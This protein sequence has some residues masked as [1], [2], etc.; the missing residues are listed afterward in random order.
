MN[1]GLAL[2]HVHLVMNLKLIHIVIYL[3]IHIL[4]M[5]TVVRTVVQDD[6]AYSDIIRPSDSDQANWRGV[7]Q[8]QKGL[9]RYFMINEFM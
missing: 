3:P 6:V 7:R 2:D 9:D 4:F 5:T 1:V 8:M